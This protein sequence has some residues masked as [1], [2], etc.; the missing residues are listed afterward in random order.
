M[1]S[2]GEFLVEFAMFL[3]PIRRQYSGVIF[4][5]PVRLD[6]KG[7]S[8]TELLTVNTDLTVLRVGQERFLLFFIPSYSVDETD[9]DSIVRAKAAIYSACS[10]MLRHIG[11]GFNDLETVYIAGG[12]G[13]FLDIGTAQAIGLLP[14]LP[15]EKFRFVGNASLTGSY[16]LLLSEEHR[17]RQAELT[18]RMT[19]LDLSSEPHY[20][21]EY[22][23]ALFI[24]HTD[25]TR[26]PSANSASQA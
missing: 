7:L 18:K 24:P 15:R 2:R 6:H 21:D 10:L 1:T 17:R 16:M 19:Y 23:A 25:A 8:W 5:F 3:P 14:D 9:I 11:I 13:R 26:F 22:T 20:M 4:A 12:F